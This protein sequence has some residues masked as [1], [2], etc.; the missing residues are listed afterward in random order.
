MAIDTLINSVD[1]TASGRKGAGLAGCKMDIKRIVALGLLEKGTF[2]ENTIDKAYMRELQQAGK[3]EM[4]QGV[5]SMTNATAEDNITT[6][7]GSGIKVVTGK[8][9]YEF[10]ATFDNGL[11]FHKALTSFSSY[12]AFDLILF[13]VN[14]NM[15]FTETKA[16]MPKGFTLGM[17]ENGAYGIANGT[18]SNS[19]T[20]T[21]QMTDRAEFDDRVSFKTGDNL[22][23]SAQ[24]LTATND[25]Y[26]VVSPITASSTSIVVSVKLGDRTHAVTGLLVGDFL[27]KRNGTIITPSAVSYSSTTELYTLTVTSNTAADIVDVALDGIVL[28]AA[29]V[30]YKSDTVTVVVS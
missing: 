21:F 28:T 19:Q 2:L 12:N 22:D 26:L 27:V 20:V 23:F 9:P 4:L 8:N 11:S 7:E 6:R 15:F 13:D 16:G 1:C 10:T 5:V 14:N 25:V 29:D 3:L 24:D 18:D 17:F 30:L